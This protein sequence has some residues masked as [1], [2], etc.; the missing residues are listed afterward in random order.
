MK[1][2]HEDSLSEKEANGNLELASW[3]SVEKLG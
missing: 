1:R 2:L 3:I